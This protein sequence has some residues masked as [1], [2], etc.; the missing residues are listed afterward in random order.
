[1]KMINHISKYLR[2]SFAALILPCLALGGCDSD[3][4]SAPDDNPRNAGMIS[5]TLRSSKLGSRA[6][7]SDVDAL[8]ENLIKSAYLCF[9]PQNN[10]DDKPLFV[11][12]VADIGKRTT[13]TVEVA[14]SRDIKD[15]LFPPETDVCGVYVIANPSQAMTPPTVDMTFDQIKKLAISGDFASSAVQE[16]FTM[17]GTDAQVKISGRGT[18]S[19]SAEGR[20]Q[21]QRCASKITLAVKVEDILE[22]KDEDGNVLE[23]WQAQ[24][25]NMSVL[26]TDGVN[27]SQIASM[28]YIHDLT[29]NDY[30]STSRNAENN[31]HRERKL[32]HSDLLTDEEF[33]YVLNSPF[34]TFPTQWDAASA[35]SRQLFMTLMVPW[36]KQG[37]QSFRTCYYTVP[38][39]R[40]SQIGRNISYRVNLY[41]SMLGSFTPDTPFELTPLSY[42]A[43]D[44]GEVTT[45]VE[46]AD[47]RYLVVDQTAYT[48]NNESSIQI[49]VYTS[50][51]T[52]VTA[53]T[54]R[55]F[56][57]NTYSRGNEQPVDITEARYD[58]TLN[59]G[60]TIYTCEF[61]NA[62]AADNSNYLNFEHDM[63]TWTP[64][65]SGGAEVTFPKTSQTQA[66]NALNSISYYT[67]T[68]QAAY[69]R[70]IT[71]VTIA[72]KDRPEYNQ[73]FTITQYPQMYIT[74]TPNYYPT[75]GY[76]TPTQ[77]NVFVNGSQATNTG[78]YQLYQLGSQGNSNSNQYVITITQLNENE[79]YIIGDPRVS[80]YTDLKGWK[81]NFGNNNQT[82][83]NNNWAQA[84]D[85]SDT[86]RRLQYYYPTDESTAKAR[87]IAPSFR[88]ASSYGVCPNTNNYDQDK[89]R[90]ASYQELSRPAG[91]WRI[92]TVA[93]IEY[94]MKLSQDG[95]IPV[96]FNTNTYY[97]SAQG[98][99]STNDLGTYGNLRTPDNTGGS[100]AVRCVYDEWYWGNDT[101][102]NTGT[103]DEPKYTFTWGDRERTAVDP[104][105]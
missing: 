62:D 60:N 66:D 47:S 72:H 21:L 23:T 40:E 39:I 52:V 22:I 19:E 93:E 100:A 64:R 101:I 12:Y 4:F 45:D 63:L 71:T 29:D 105:P 76:A 18:T 46:L 57:Y 48:L 80:E 84:N 103:K 31:L 94:I 51:E 3:N 59:H 92:P 67:P 16:S 83:P 5:L 89:A 15:A 81:N 73:T 25:D 61:H 97:M 49:P 41:V 37:E 7:E 44:W 70:Y 74:S 20:V 95:K 6:V 38:V 30:Y 96:L 82:A 1:M 102:S 36:R 28:A 17:D 26:V 56:L 79:D 77:G 2:L 35:D 33:P 32:V 13:A 24:L 91:R 78:W 27:H 43:I 42:Y 8:N 75:T 54:M 10:P 58:E 65:S 88:V 34:Y 68:D 87:W 14:L 53:K 98:R 11:E 99:I 104:N 9:Y 85:M 90:C 69:S 50:H 86:R 55:Y